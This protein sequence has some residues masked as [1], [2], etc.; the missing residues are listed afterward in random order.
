MA[1]QM[2]RSRA[3][4]AMLT[5]SCLLL[6]VTMRA[7]EVPAPPTPTPQQ[8][9]AAISV[10]EIAAR[11]A[12]VSTLLRSLAPPPSPQ[13]EMIEKRFPS[14]RSKID[15]DRAASESVLR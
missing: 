6:P 13:I 2:M 7:E 10:A 4:V 14:I 11:A 3:V 9:P 15:L 5:L 1:S 12:Q 8:P